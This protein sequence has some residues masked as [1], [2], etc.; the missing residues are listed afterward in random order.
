MVHGRIIYVGFLGDAGLSTELKRNKKLTLSHS[1]S[2]RRAVLITKRRGQRARRAVPHITFT[3]TLS[4]TNVGL[5]RT[6]RV[7]FQYNGCL[8][9]ACQEARRIL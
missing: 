2:R 7:S 5:Y 6:L 9:A 1:W 3:V 4:Q 8:L